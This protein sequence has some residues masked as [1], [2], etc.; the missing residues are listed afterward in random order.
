MVLDAVRAYLQVPEN[1]DVFIIPPAE[2]KRHDDFKAHFVLEGQDGMVWRA[3]CGTG[4]SRFFWQVIFVKWAALVGNVIPR[5]LFSWNAVSTW[6]HTLMMRTAR[7]Q[8]HQMQWLYET[9][10]Q[11]GVKLKPVTILGQGQTYEYLQRRY[12]RVQEGMLIE[13]S[14][15]YV[16]ETLQDLDLD[17]T[18]KGVSATW[19]G[20]ESLGQRHR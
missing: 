15:R 8:T 20:K 14:L 16:E 4:V 11:R 1:D 10:L 19:I 7:D 12:T 13:P 3:S 9:L 17:P 18:S 2:W 6:K 5:N